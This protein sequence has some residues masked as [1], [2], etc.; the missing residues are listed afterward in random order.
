MSNKTK[1]NVVTRVDWTNWIKEGISNKIIKYYEYNSFSSVKEIGFRNSRKVYRANWKSSRNP[2]A[3]KTI[4]EDTAEKIIY[5]LKLQ[6]EKHFYDNIIKFYGVTIDYR[7]DSSRKYMLVMEYADSGTLRRYLKENFSSLTWNDKSVIAYQL[8]YAVSCLH[9]ENIIHGDLHSDNV[10][11]H[12]NTIKL[13]DFGVNP[14]R[15][16]SDEYSLIKGD[17]Y[18]VGLLLWEISS[19]RPPFNGENSYRRP[20]PNTPKDY[21]TIYT[22][23]WKE[24]PPTIYDIV[25]RLEAIMERNFETSNDYQLYDF[26]REVQNSNSSF[27]EDLYS[28]NSDEDIQKYISSLER[29]EKDFHLQN[30]NIQQSSFEKTTKDFR[31]Y[32]SKS[33]IQKPISSFAKDFYSCNSDIDISSLGRTE[34]FQLHDSNSSFK[35]L[36]SERT[37]KDFRSCDSNSNSLSSFAKDFYTCNSKI[38]T[39]QCF[40][41]LDKVAEDSY[42]YNSD[43]DIQQPSFVRTTTKDFRPYNSNSNVQKPISSF[44]KDSYSYNSD[45]DIQQPSFVR[46]T[47]KDFRPY[48]S[49]SNVQKPISSFAKDFYSYSS[50]TDIQQCISSFERDFQLHD[51]N[52]NYENNNSYNS[53]VNNQQS[54]SGSSR[55]NSLPYDS[56]IEDLIGSINN[57]TS[58]SRNNNN[59]SPSDFWK[60]LK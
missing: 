56:D 32:D 41:S 17:I 25:A 60:Y 3:L 7:Y 33:N 19:G 43:A 2:L 11:V 45:V 36:G 18:N 5:W 30:S 53:N 39:Q 9:D 21:V 40:S 1:F 26:N 31:S 47:T 29:T 35:Q 44:T 49:N 23:C 22:D 55:I 50:D 6:R 48:N 46:T 59:K 14:E 38:S 20:I 12:Q 24:D 13:A 28:C 27:V 42:S 34:D 58:S 37:T 4:N 51:S 16:Y 52:S 57:D 15:F 10:L 54:I 8:A